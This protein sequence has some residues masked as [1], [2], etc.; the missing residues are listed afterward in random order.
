VIN[1]VL[2][3]AKLEAGKMEIS[4]ELITLPALLERVVAV[5]NPADADRRID[6]AIDVSPEVT[7]VVADH[8]RLEQVLTGLV[9]NAVKFTPD[10]GR[11]ELRAL[12]DPAGDL[13][14]SVSDTGIGI[15]TD[16]RE[17]IFEAFHQGNEVLDDHVQEGTGLGLS[18]ARG[19]VQL[20]G[21]RIWVDS[22]RDRGSTFTI[23]LPAAVG[24]AP[25]PVLR[26]VP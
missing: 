14:V 6:V 21:G 19:L 15:A 7:F 1:D 3:L 8:H 2:D 18:L 9:S 13:Y 5:A 20:H 24:S 26:G 17:R 10:G 4:P 12:G 23:M 16:Q 22:Q 25:E 11:I